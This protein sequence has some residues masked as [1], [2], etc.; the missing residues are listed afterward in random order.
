[1]I[2][3]LS[4]F[5]LLFLC[6]DVSF[7][8]NIKASFPSEITFGEK[9]S[10]SSQAY[11][12]ADIQLTTGMHGITYKLS[13]DP[14]VIY[15]DSVYVSANSEKLELS[16]D[17]YFEMQRV[18]SSFV[19]YS[20]TLKGRDKSLKLDELPISLDFV[21]KPETHYQ[22]IANNCEYTIE[23]IAESVTAYDHDKTQIELS[24]FVLPI[25]IECIDEG[26]TQFLIA[27]PN[28]T[29]ERCWVHIP[30]DKIEAIDLMLLFDSKGQQLDPQIKNLGDEI[31][32]NL[33]HLRAG[34]YYLNIIYTNQDKDVV[35]IVKL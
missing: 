2:K 3:V 10:I 33:S 32:M 9:K 13:F 14:D 31:E 4:L 7:S 11:L 24:P 6:V 12:G 20:L 29:K 23:F 19:L 30:P 8:Q 35:K 16:K 1:M 22:L 17:E 15:A 18:D 25:N 5:I 34:H 26:E 21:I 28:P 27:A